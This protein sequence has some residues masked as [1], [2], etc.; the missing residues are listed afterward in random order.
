M[1]TSTTP[2]SDDTWAILYEDFSNSILSLKDLA[3]KHHVPY[4]K[5]VIKARTDEWKRKPDY[6]IKK[7]THK[8][9]TAK[10]VPLSTEIDNLLELTKAQQQQAIKYMV[11]GK[12]SDLQNDGCLIEGDVPKSVEGMAIELRTEVMKKLVLAARNFNPLQLKVE[13]PQQVKA[14]LEAAKIA[15]GQDN[16]T[17]LL[18]LNMRWFD[19]KPKSL[20]SGQ[21]TV[22]KDC[23][24]DITP[25]ES[26]DING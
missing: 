18:V 4:S 8:V 23:T 19:H 26:T 13:S 11:H 6:Q 3:K 16:Q 24:L 5:L 17:N 1:S 21:D 7:A 12:S 9:N 2:I 20:H 10:N 15:A 25:S 14:L 22:M